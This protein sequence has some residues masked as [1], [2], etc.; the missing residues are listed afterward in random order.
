M[1]SSGSNIFTAIGSAGRPALSSFIRPPALLAVVQQV[2]VAAADAAREHLGQHLPGARG[3]VG[4]VVDP[5]LP[6]S[7]HRAA[8]IRP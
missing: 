5:Q 4:D 1:S 2:Q 7:H 3:R 6:V 8:R